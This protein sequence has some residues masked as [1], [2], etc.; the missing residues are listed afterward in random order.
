MENETHDDKVSK[1]TFRGKDNNHIALTAHV[2]I[3]LEETADIIQVSKISFDILVILC[4]KIY[5]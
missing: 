3:A 2:L 4:T 1:G 5:F